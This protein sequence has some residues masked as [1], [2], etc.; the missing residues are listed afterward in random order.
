MEGAPTDALLAEVERMSEQHHTNDDTVV[1]VL[2]KLLT[3]P[4]RKEAKP[5]ALRG[6]Q[7]LKPQFVPEGDPVLE[8][9]R[10]LIDP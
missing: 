10:Y 6:S 7:L 8:C 9:R 1:R 5:R 4:R 2:T 3:L